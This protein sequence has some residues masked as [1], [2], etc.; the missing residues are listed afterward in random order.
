VLALEADATCHL[1]FIVR[2]VHVPR[3]EPEQRCARV[4][5][6]P[7]VV[8]IRH[9]ERAL[10]IPSVAVAVPDQGGL[11]VVVEVGAGACQ[12]GVPGKADSK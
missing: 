3:T 9:V 2:V 10:V 5:V 1:L 11:P 4:D 6:L 7:V 8:G 12:C